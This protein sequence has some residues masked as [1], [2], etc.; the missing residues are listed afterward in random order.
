V[1]IFR[2]WRK[3]TWKWTGDQVAFASRSL[4][5]AI[6]LLGLTKFIDKFFHHCRDFE[7]C[8]WTLIMTFQAY[9]RLIMYVE[10]MNIEMKTLILSPHLSPLW[11]QILCWSKIHFICT[12]GFS[13]GARDF[14]ALQFAAAVATQ[15]TI[16]YAP[17]I[18][19]C[20]YSRG[21]WGVI[22]VYIAVLF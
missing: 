18:V 7:M 3:L 13:F 19:R 22:L 20:V 6:L 21:F 5:R 17:C 9:T 16:H 1:L 8:L 12:L 10:M 14:S 2:L 4:L 11:S 15:H